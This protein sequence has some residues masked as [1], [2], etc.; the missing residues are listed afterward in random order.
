VPTAAASVVLGIVCDATEDIVPAA[1]NS[2]VR[3]KAPLTAIG[4]APSG[5]A[6]IGLKPSISSYITKNMLSVL[7]G[8]TTSLNAIYAEALS[9]APA[10]P[11]GVL[12]SPVPVEM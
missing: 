12:A 6:A 8:G 1:A 3:A 5:L 7:G 4:P 10:P 2:D 9:T 11:V